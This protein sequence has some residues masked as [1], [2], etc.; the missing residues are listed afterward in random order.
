MPGDSEF[1]CRHCATGI[2]EHTPL[3]HWCLNYARI[4]THFK[5]DERVFGTRTG[6]MSSGFDRRNLQEVDRR[7]LTPTGRHWSKPELQQI[8]RR[9]TV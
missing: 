4:P 8:P 9:P 5:R 3:F 1:V 7:E 2:D 6:R